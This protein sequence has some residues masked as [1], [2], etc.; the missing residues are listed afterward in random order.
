MLLLTASVVFYFNSINIKKILQ[1][2]VG[3]NCANELMTHTTYDMLHTENTKFVTC[4]TVQI[5]V[6]RCMTVDHR[7]MLDAVLQ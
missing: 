1:T 7:R 5:C 6:T 2:V 4:I 3:L